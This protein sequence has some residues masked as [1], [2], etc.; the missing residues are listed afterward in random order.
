MSEENWGAVMRNNDMLHGL[1]VIPARVSKEKLTLNGIERSF[2]PGTPA[3]YNT[4]R[5]LTWLT[6]YILVAFTLKP[7]H[8][9]FYKKPHDVKGDTVS[10]AWSLFGGG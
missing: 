4:Y 8:I 5:I 2:L 9:E 10:D 7:R 1:R 6:F 3:E